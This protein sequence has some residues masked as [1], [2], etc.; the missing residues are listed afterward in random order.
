MKGQL[1]GRIL[2][3]GSKV[4][5]IG[6]EQRVCLTRDLMQIHTDAMVLCIAVE[7]HAE[8]KQRVWAVFNTRHHAARRESCLLD[9]TVEVLRV[10]VED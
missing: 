4:M 10:L 7:E 2:S 9:I 1:T 8:L 5:S 6:V 3:H